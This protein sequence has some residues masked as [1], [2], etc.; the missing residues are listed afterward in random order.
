MGDNKSSAEQG[1]LEELPTFAEGANAMEAYTNSENADELDIQQDFTSKINQ[2]VSE[3]PP[4]VKQQRSTNETRPDYNTIG[5]EP[6][7]TSF[8]NFQ[9]ML[10]E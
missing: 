7:Q 4:G 3:I 9:K 8:Q 1:G 2:F 6:I 5:A 10:K